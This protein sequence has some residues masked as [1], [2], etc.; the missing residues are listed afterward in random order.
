MNSAGIVESC[1]VKRGCSYLAQNRAQE[2]TRGVSFEVA[3]LSGSVL[4]EAIEN[5]VKMKYGMLLSL[6][7]SRA[8]RPGE[9]PTRPLPRPTS[10]LRGEVMK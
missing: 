8:L 5:K 2:V 4:F 10:P 1:L 7:K 6:W 9:G 3:I